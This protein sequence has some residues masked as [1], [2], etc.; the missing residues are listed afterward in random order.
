MAG[1]VG[2]GE[3]R[4]GAGVDRPGAVEL[5]GAQMLERLRAAMGV[6]G[7]EHVERTVVRDRPR[8]EYAR[9]SRVLEVSL[10][11]SESWSQTTERVDHGRHARRFAAVGLHR[12]VR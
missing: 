4:D 5:G 12:V 11:V 1:A 9:G 10:E 2:L 3:Q 8:H 6:V 7:H